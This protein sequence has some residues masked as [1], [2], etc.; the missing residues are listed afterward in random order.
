MTPNIAVLSDAAK[1]ASPHSSSGLRA[2]NLNV[3]YHP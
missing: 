3:S 2:A 1:I